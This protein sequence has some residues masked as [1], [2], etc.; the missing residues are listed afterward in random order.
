M[1][2]AAVAFLVILL[3]TACSPQPSELPT[4]RIVVSPAAQP[5]SEAVARCVPNN[6]DVAFSI[7]MQ[8][9]S[10]ADLEGSDLLIRLGEPGEAGF[11]AQ[12]AWEQI[13]LIVNPGNSVEIS[14]TAAADLFG[15][16]IQNWSELN[17]EDLPV[18]LWAG[19]DSDEARQA[20][21]SEVLLS[22]VSS[23]TH[24]ASNPETALKAVAQDPGAV[25]ILPAAWADETVREVDMGLQVPVIAIAGEEPTGPLR[26]LLA[27]LQSPLGQEELS[28]QYAPFQ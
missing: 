17:G 23:N 18:N 27:C 2:K 10:T 3:F 16:R 24:I 14:S 1:K 7:E 28:K 4:L 20:F 8:Y 22:S 5:I 21:E 11:A 6:G 26:E 15:E 25:A 13:A 9:P 12:L 19:P